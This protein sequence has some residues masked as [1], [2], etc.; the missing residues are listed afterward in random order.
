MFILVFRGQQTVKLLKFIIFVSRRNFIG[1][2][3]VCGSLFAKTTISMKNI[4]ISHD[5]GTHVINYIRKKICKING[6]LS[7]FDIEWDKIKS[8][9]KNLEMLHN[10]IFRFNFMHITMLIEKVGVVKGW[11]KWCVG[12]FK[13]KFNVYF[14][15]FL[16]ETRRDIVMRIQF[17]LW[18]T[19]MVKMLG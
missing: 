12:E 15:W 6:K 7:R 18:T 13:E 11:M 8:S 5:A 2:C 3:L 19:L 1:M 4:F 9:W 10:W 17:P 16:K 14:L